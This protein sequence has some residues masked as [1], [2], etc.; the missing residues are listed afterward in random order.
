MCAWGTPSVGLLQ[1]ALGESGIVGPVVALRLVETQG[2]ALHLRLPLCWV[3][4]V[5][6][7]L[8]SNLDA[9][10]WEEGSRKVI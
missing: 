6:G 10:D 4:I 1:P 2:S 5:S 7:V 9:A 3:E 8:H